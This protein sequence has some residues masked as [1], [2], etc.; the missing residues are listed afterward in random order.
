MEHRRLG[1]SDLE[2]SAIALGS[3]LTYSGGVGKRQTEA[4]TR[5]AFDAGITFFDT[6]NVYGRGAAERAWGE[7]LRDYPRDSYAI[8]TKLY[9]PMSAT[10]RGLSREQVHKQIDGSLARLGLDHVDLYQCHRYDE[11]TP[12]EETM[13]ALTEVVAAGKARHIGF[14]EWPVE[15]VREALALPGVA[16]FVSSQPQYSALWRAPE[17][18]LIPLCEAN[19]IS[20]IVWSPLAQGVLTG[21]YRAGEAPPAGTRAASRD[22]S[23][24][25]GQWLTRPVLDAVDRL[26]PV[27][28]EA[29]L[30]MSQLALGWVLRQGNVAAAIVGASRPEQV[31]ENARA[32][33]VRLS[34]DTLRAVDEA[35][36]LVAIT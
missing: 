13:Q 15:R 24:F 34:D 23:R 32:A 3:W 2:V 17:A 5:A 8:A 30:T 7:I 21:K 36:L 4:C 22:M 35:L 33:E 20:Q 25:I 19:G 1:D 31:H 28:E 10:D 26:W 6:A 14:S 16:K 12:L 11:Q 29:G 18:Q 27:A 9:Y